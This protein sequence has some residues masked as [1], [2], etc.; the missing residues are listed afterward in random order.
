MVQKLLQARSMGINVNNNITPPTEIDTPTEI[1]TTTAAKGSANKG[2]NGDAITD[3]T[4]GN[5][6]L[7]AGAGKTQTLEDTPA[8]QKAINSITDF[9]IRELMKLLVAAFAELKTADRERALNVLNSTVSA[10]ETKIAAM[11]TAKEE[12]YKAAIANAIG[13]IVGG[14]L[15]V[16]TSITA[17]VSSGKG[18]SNIRKK[19][20]EAKFE[21]AQKGINYNP[22]NSKSEDSRWSIAGQTLFSSSQGIG[23]IVS[24]A[25]GIF[26][27]KYSEAKTEAEIMQ[28]RADAL[29]EI[30]RQAQD[31]Y[32]KGSDSLQQFIDK[33]LNIMQQ[34][35]QNAAQT[36]KSIANI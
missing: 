1:G 15:S 31:Q 29:L 36:E 21:T 34:L 24:G 27:A 33:V 26:A 9:D 2:I 35:L 14:G 22:N 12:Q 8:V 28:T 4:Y 16:I 32:T 5:Y 7:L 19:N 25:A 30:L 3:K 17:G 6:A 18:L 20:N 23:Q 10:L 11:E 13:S